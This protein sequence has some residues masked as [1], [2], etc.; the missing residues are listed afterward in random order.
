MQTTVKLN[1]DGYDE[2]DHRIVCRAFIAEHYPSVSLNEDSFIELRL[3]TRPFKGAECIKLQ[4]IDAAWRYEW[5]DKRPNI[6]TWRPIYVYLAE[7]FDQ[8][9]AT[10]R[11]YVH[12]K[13]I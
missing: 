13:N 6:L 9:K 7:L 1:N 12:I 4:R 10:T 2:H 11:V 3:S 8:I 5:F